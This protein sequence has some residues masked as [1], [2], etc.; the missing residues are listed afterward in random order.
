MPRRELLEE[1]VRHPLSSEEGSAIPS[2]A[3]WGA[4]RGNMDGRRMRLY[5]GAGRPG[6]TH[7]GTQNVRFYR[8][9]GPQISM[10]A[11][12]FHGGGTHLWR[13]LFSLPQSRPRGSSTRA[14]GQSQGED[15]QPRG[16]SLKKKATDGLRH[17]L[18]VLTSPI[19]AG[20]TLEYGFTCFAPR[21]RIFLTC[22]RGIP[23]NKRHLAGAARVATCFAR[24]PRV[25]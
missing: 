9:F 10:G 15:P 8:D 19:G 16:K 24:S 1:I 14:G 12:N 25:G 7:M 22:P 23:C 5:K 4:R 17:A 21:L 18:D 6:R 13:N 3:Y 2:A 20:A 11:E